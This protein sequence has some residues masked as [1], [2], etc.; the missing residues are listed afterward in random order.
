MALYLLTGNLIGLGLGPT[1]IALAT[2]YVFGYDAAIG[3]SIAL[4]TVI[5]CP[6]ATLILWRSLPS[7]NKLLEE[8]R[9]AELSINTH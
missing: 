6:L 5:L 7:I 2:D 8:Q 1:I 4:C 9:T 3:K